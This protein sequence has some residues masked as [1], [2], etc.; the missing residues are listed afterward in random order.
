[1][2]VFINAANELLFLHA[3]NS[4]SGLFPHWCFTSSRESC[5]VQTI[6]SELHKDGTCTEDQNEE[7]VLQLNIIL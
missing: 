5:V 6:F 3:M 2:L 4:H 1:M 7:A